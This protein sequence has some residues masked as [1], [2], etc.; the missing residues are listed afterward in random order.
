MKKGKELIKFRLRCLV[1]GDVTLAQT[2]EDFNHDVQEASISHFLKG[3]AVGGVV[4]LL[5]MNY[6]ITK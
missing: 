1:N 3:F 5:I 2:I 6:L 4:A